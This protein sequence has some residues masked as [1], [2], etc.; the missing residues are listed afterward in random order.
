MA[1][2]IANRDNVIP[3]STC[4]FTVISPRYHFLSNGVLINV[5]NC[6]GIDNG[7]RH[8]R[9]FLWR[10]YHFLG[11]CT[12][13]LCC[14]ATVELVLLERALS[15]LEVLSPQWTVLDD[16]LTLYTPDVLITERLVRE[17]HPIPIWF[18]REIR[19]YEKTTII[20]ISTWKEFR[21]QRF[22]FNYSHY[23]KKLLFRGNFFLCSSKEALKY[24][25]PSFWLVR[26]AH[27]YF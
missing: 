22:H 7:R 15:V 24:W 18:A 21:F 14:F 13:I 8:H 12:E 27:Q 3:L 26:N 23:K 11:T 9:R 4:Q 6:S 10:W 17:I 1:N 25:V 16:L 19:I 20:M 2:V 5:I